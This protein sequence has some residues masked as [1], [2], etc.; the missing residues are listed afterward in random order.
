MMKKII[1]MLSLALALTACGAAD[2]SVADDPDVMIETSAFEAAEPVIYSGSGYS[3]EIPDTWKKSDVQQEGIDCALQPAY[4]HNDTEAATLLIFQVNEGTGESSVAEIGALLEEQYK[5][6][7][8]YTVSDSGA[9]TAGSCDGYFVTIKREAEGK[10]L[11]TKHIVTVDDSCLYSII[12]TAAEEQFDS[13]QSE[14]QAIIDSFT[15]D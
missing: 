1:I 11:C 8:D 4:P 7:A 2:S 5:S 14:A 15:I 6:M 10:T 3:I 12:L 9:C 13:A